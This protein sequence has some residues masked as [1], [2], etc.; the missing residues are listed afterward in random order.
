MD[1]GE[2]PELKYSESGWDFFAPKPFECTRMFCRVC[3]EEMQ[4]KREAL[5]KVEWDADPELER[6]TQWGMSERRPHDR[7]YCL[8]SAKAWHK[9]VLALRKEIVAT[10]SLFLQQLLEKEIGQILQE[11]IPTKEPYLKRHQ[12]ELVE[13]TPYISFFGEYTPTEVSSSDV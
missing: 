10:A 7:F 4:V 9:Q 1:R 3:E 13:D 12:D 2:A 8:N 6:M 5:L 11:K